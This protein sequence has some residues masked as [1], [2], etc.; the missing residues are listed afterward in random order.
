MKK[1]GLIASVDIHKVVEDGKSTITLDQVKGDLLYTYHRGHKGYRVIP[2]YKLT[3][4]ELLDDVTKVKTQYES[5]LNKTN[6]PKIK[7][8]T[9]GLAS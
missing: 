1:I 8:G 6:H 5:I 2:F 9:L 7:I 3:N 4:K